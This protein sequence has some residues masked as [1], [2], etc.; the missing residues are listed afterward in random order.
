[1]VTFSK[2]KYIY[3]FFGLKAFLIQYHT[4]YWKLKGN[5]NITM[6]EWITL[7]NS[8]KLVRGK[9]E[10]PQKNVIRGILKVLNFA[11]DKISGEILLPGRLTDHIYPQ[12]KEKLIKLGKSFLRSADL[13]VCPTRQLEFVPAG[14]CKVMFMLNSL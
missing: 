2:L 3:I 12:N 14:H 11:V 4:Y 10:H 8:L 1:M 13:Q 5:C 6:W 7:K 9:W